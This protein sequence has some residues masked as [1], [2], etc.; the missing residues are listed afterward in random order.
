MN[1]TKTMKQMALGCLLAVGLFSLPIG[2]QAAPYLYENDT[3]GFSIECPQEPVGVIDLSTIS[4]EEKGV[5]LVFENEGYTI[6]YAWGISIDGFTDDE[7]PDL[8]KLGE[9]EKKDLLNKLSAGNYQIAAIYNVDGKEVLYTVDKGE[10]KRVITFIR[11]DKYRYAVGL[12]ENPT[13]TKER[14]QAYQQGIM[15]F[16]SK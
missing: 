9:Q 5:L 4:P 14:I 1:L 2:A 12:I 15:T 6:N 11:G 16:K 10:N 7:L 3:Y 13:S 8:S